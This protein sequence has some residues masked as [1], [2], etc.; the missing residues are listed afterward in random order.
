[1]TYDPHTYWPERYRVQG[2]T[3]VAKNGDPDSYVEQLEE[4]APYLERLLPVGGSVLDYGCGP[5]RFRP[6][7]EGMGCEYDGYDLIPELGTIDR[8][9]TNAYDAAIAVYVLQ[10]IVD[11]AD[12]AAALY[13]V[14]Q[15]LRVGGHFLVVDH[16]PMSAPAA[17]MMPRGVE[18]IREIFG[19]PHVVSHHAII[20]HWLG[21][22][23]K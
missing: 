6:V 10:H 23:S 20:G 4:I 8:V 21:V 2:D 17:H 9:G 7:I 11:E 14:W 22:F 15:G 13:T 16:E 5:G 3:Y 1:M 18:P 12:Y 19:G